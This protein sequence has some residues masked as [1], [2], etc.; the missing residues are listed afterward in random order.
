MGFLGGGFLGGGTDESS[1]HSTVNTTVTTETTTQ[2]HD[3]GLTG[4]NAVDLL[5]VE[6]ANIG[7]V[8][9]GLADKNAGSFGVVNQSFSNLIDAFKQVDYNANALVSNI[10]SSGEQ[11]L[12]DIGSRQEAS[13]QQLLTTYKETTN[14]ALVLAEGQQKLVLYGLIAIAA[15]FALGIGR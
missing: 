5:N 7:A 15:F 3:I 2:L 11:L 9:L 8:Q 1:T 13:Q 10:Q 14:P 12:S 4:Q 6:T